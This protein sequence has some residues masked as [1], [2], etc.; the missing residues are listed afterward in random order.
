MPEVTVSSTSRSSTSEVPLLGLVQVLARAILISCE[1]NSITGTK[2][3]TYEVH[4]LSGT[5]R[6]DSTVRL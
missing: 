2:E 6:T 5:H 4:T 3:D 1:T